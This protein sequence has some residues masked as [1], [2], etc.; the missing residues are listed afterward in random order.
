MPVGFG[1]RI[2]VRLER[3]QTI[4]QF[5]LK[6]VGG[7][8]GA[9]GQ[10]IDVVLYGKKIGAR[11]KVRLSR[12]VV[13]LRL[14]DP[15][16]ELFTH[17]GVREPRRLAARFV[18]M[19]GRECGSREHPFNERRGSDSFDRA[20]DR[21]SGIRMQARGQ[22]NP[23][24]RRA[25]HGIGGKLHEREPRDERKRYDNQDTLDE[26]DPAGRRQNFTVKFTSARVCVRL[27]FG[28]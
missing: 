22:R 19:S 1:H 26:C 16:E 20:I 13:A 28:T 4:L 6:C 17:A 21:Y 8:R 14:R 18:E 27:R 15:S 2:G 5:Q 10:P 12:S 7:D 24:P 9:G 3:F 11:E 23:R 25:E